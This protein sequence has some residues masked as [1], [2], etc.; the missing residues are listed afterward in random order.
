MET[1]TDYN[2]QAIEFL[3]S[4]NTQLEIV[5]KEFGNMQWDKDGQKRNIF[6]CT[7]S[8]EKH[9][10]TFDFGSSVADSCGFESEMSQLIESD[11]ISVYAGLKSVNNKTLKAGVILNMTKSELLTCENIEKYVEELQDQIQRVSSDNNRKAYKLFD[12]GKISRDVRDSRLHGRIENGIAYQCIKNAI[13][14]KTDELNNNMVYSKSLQGEDNVT[15]TQYDILA[16]ITKYD[17]YTFEDFCSSYGY[18][19]DSRQAE[20]TFNAVTDEWNN[21]SQLFNVDELELLS[22]IN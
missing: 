19:E 11:K 12:D 7:L 13:K 16:A 21:I 2:Q 10:Y 5:F 18:D 22:E 6:S 15:P 9:S 4:A 17:P 20:K 3:Q 1:T 14:R 8:N